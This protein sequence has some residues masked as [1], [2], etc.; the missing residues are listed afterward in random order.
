[1][2]SWPLALSVLAFQSTSHRSYVTVAAVDSGDF[3]PKA[4]PMK[5]SCRVLFR[6]FTLARSVVSIASPGLTSSVGFV[7]PFVC[8]VDAPSLDVCHWPSPATPATVHA[9]RSCPAAAADGV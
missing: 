6:T 8:V 1:L 2:A 3:I 5:S 7:P 9:R 4:R